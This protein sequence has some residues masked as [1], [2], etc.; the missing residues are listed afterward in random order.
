MK[1]IGDQ[2][3]WTSE[4]PP[5][6]LELGGE[7]VSLLDLA[8]KIPRDL[9]LSR[10]IGVA[11]RLTPS[12]ILDAG[13]RGLRHVVQ[14]S[15]PR[16]AEEIRISTSMILQPAQ[17]LESPGEVILG[18]TGFKKQS[19]SFTSST[20]KESVITSVLND[21]K[22]VDQGALVR[23]AA[24]LIVDELFTNAIF[25]APLDR[26]G[27]PLNAHRDRSESVT[28]QEGLAA[29]IFVASDEDWL[30]VG[31]TDP[32]GSFVHQRVIQR[33]H[34][35]YQ[36]GVGAAMRSSGGGAGIGCRMM[37]DLSASMYVGVAPGKQTTIVFRLPLRHG[38]RHREQ[39]PKS[40]HLT[41]IGDIRMSQLRVEQV[42]KDSTLKIEFYGP[43]DEDCDFT[44]I[45][46]TG[47]K[48]VELELGGVTSINSCG[49]REWIRWIKSTPAGTE[50][51]YQQCPKVMVDQINMIE[52]FLPE[53][54]RVSSF[55]VPYFCPE[56]EQMS[57]ILLE[58]GKDYTGPKVTVPPT[59]KCSHCGKTA[60]IDV[61]EEQ[62]FR[63]LEG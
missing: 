10:T 32:F 51:I 1:W 22:A 28:L 54:A 11:Q 59:C 58:A 29:E 57:S 9:A 27:F 12:K 48:R 38:H 31:C 21:L 41:M 18:K 14:A 7:E 42:R 45:P 61:I 30:L 52:G 49:I 17:F 25:N 55:Q 44:K 15:D 62:Y 2:P 24:N 19:Y 34:D 3:P 26:D 37:F 40:F 47:A 46:I 20:Q 6:L 5:N 63:F 33:I 39:M 43:I 16:F 60:E 53:F 35:C 4:V 13:F 36:R 8:Q 23:D 56:C 50:V